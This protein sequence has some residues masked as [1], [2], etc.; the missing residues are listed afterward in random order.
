MEAITF[1]EEVMSIPSVNG[2]DDEGKVAEYLYDYFQSCGLS[3]SIDR[4]DSRHAN[5]T[6]WMDGADPKH[7]VLWN[8]HLDTVPYGDRD[9][10]KYAPEIPVKEN[11]CLYGRG[12]SDMKSGLAAMAWVLGQMKKQGKVSACNL[13]FVGTCDEER[14]G[15]GASALLNK[16]ILNRVDAMVIGEPTGNNLGIA[17]KGCLWLEITGKGKTSHG[18]YPERGWNAISS[19][20]E[21]AAAVKE[22]TET[23]S[24]PILGTATA[25]VTQITGGVAPNMTPDSCTL[26]MDIRLVPPMTAEEV[27]RWAEEAASEHG[28]K[29]Q[30]KFEY[31]LKICNNRGAIEISENHPL[32]ERFREELIRSGFAPAYTGINYFTDASVFIREI[33]RVPVLLFGPGD[34]ELAHQPNESVDLKLYE[35]SIQI[36]QRI[37]WTMDEN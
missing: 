17:Q 34:P 30:G 6:A 4:I 2:T 5:V 26:L 13:L 29:S 28:K 3:C 21:I 25:Q 32:T 19:C 22:K 27:I 9:A 12:A 33:P 15:L 20:M 7:I 23:I 35:A 16:G 8:G 14:G 18:A 24:H 11:G 1:L 37:F 10:W 36:L 31:S